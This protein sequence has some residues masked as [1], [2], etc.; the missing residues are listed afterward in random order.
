MDIQNTSTHRVGQQTWESSEI[1][2]QEK[3]K[4]KTKLDCY[5]ELDDKAPF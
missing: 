3:A 5:T 1:L 4:T 2:S